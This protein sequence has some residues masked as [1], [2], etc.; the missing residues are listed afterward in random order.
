VSVNIDAMTTTGASVHNWAGNVEFSAADVHRPGSVAELQGI[1]A[2]AERV[3]AL[4]SG[5]SFNRIADTDRALVRL[6]GLPQV[7]RLV[8]DRRTVTVSAGMRYAEVAAALQAKGWALANMASLPHISVAGSVA[9]GTH[10]SGDTNPGLAAAVAGLRMVGADG[11]LLALARGDERFPGAVVALGALGVVTELTL[12]VVPS[13]DLAQDVHD[14]VPLDAVAAAFDETYGAGYS[15]STFTDWR[16]GQG[17]VWVKRR[18]DQPAQPDGWLGG[19]LA[20]GPRHPVPGMPPDYCTVQ[21]GVPGPWCD[22]LPH[23][24]AEFTPSSGEE[25]QSEVLLP[26]AAAGEA[27]EAL[28]SLGDRI[29]PVLQVSEIRTVAADALWLSPAYG[30]PTVGFHFT[31]RPDT[32]AVLPVITEIESRLLPLGGRPHWGKLTTADPAAVAARYPRAA[33]FRRLRKELD[34][35]CRFSNPFVDAYLPLG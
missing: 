29:A 20:D 35:T 21:G 10:G 3:R 19:R 4:G 6:D 34:P 8:P 17:T 9:T 33:D 28:R 24:R 18:P 22:R 30:R 1:V 5:H 16:S 32:R 27:M 11:E 25:L 12:D 13:F 31:W 2:G 26:R 15:V 23:F 14:A 7:V